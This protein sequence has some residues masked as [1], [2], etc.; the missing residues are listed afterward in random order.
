MSKN[1]GHKG[2]FS[3]VESHETSAGI[4][5]VDYCIGSVESHI[6]LKYG[7]A[8][9]PKIRPPQVKWF[10][11]RVKAHGHPWMFTCMQENSGKYWM[12]HTGANMVR[13]KLHKERQIEAWQNC[14][15]AMWEGSMG[16]DDLIGFL[17]MK[18]SK[19]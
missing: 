17:T 4:P 7:R 2:H 19:Q 13:Y 5:D 1:I 9:P 14:S 3:R 16:W 10:R 15:I 11:D 6:E 18:W 12:L 8:H